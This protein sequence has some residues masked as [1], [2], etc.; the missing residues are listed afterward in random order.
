MNVLEKI[1]SFQYDAPINV[2][3]LIESFGIS[4]DRKANLHADIA[5]QI[6]RIDDQHFR[7]SVNANDHYY[8]RRFTM[9][10]ELGH[11][12]MHKDLLG[13]GTDDNRAY[14]SVDA[15][16]FHNTNITPQHETEANRFAAN[17]LMPAHLVKRYF[18]E[19]DG[20]LEKLS[21]RFQVSS[22]AMKHR[23]ASLDLKPRAF[24]ERVP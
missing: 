21:K 3:G 11:Y 24:A 20:D 16:K 13:A 5:G 19:A 2:E 17:L 9:A 15:G 6:E 14:R 23:L 12:L 4:L 8:R 18:Y 1:K 22:E 10:H 7:I